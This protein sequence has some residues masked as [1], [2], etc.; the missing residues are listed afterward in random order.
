MSKLIEPRNMNELVEPIDRVI[1]NLMKEITE[2]EWE[3]GDARHL[4]SMHKSLC[5]E[6]D[7][8]A[9]YYFKF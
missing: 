3:G 4:W 7:A 2:V 6:R 5:E 8:G 9:K 1:R